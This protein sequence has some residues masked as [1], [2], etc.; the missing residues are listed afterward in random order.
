MDMKKTFRILIILLWL[1]S[2][3]A[4]ILSL[5]TSLEI[6]KVIVR[7]ICIMISFSGIIYVIFYLILF[8]KYKNIRFIAFLISFLIL[9]NI[10]N[11]KCPNE[12]RKVCVLY[13]HGHIPFRTIEYQIQ[14]E[15]E[16]NNKRTVDV[17]KINC[18]LSLVNNVDET[19]IIQPWIKVDDPYS[20]HQS[21]TKIN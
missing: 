7:K 15:G 5:F 14:K 11:K 3:L 1:L 2:S 18:F 16:F 9:V 21:P 8:R 19:K 10:I 20:K 13:V 4:I 12:W 6:T 17:I